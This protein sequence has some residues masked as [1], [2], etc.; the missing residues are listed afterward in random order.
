MG[1]TVAP[2]ASSTLPDEFSGG[3]T[4][5]HLGSLSVN[6]PEPRFP[7]GMCEQSPP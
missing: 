5:A 7:V 3:R 1:S 2:L 6:H 4:P